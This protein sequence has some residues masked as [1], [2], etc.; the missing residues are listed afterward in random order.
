MKTNL[1]K[2]LLYT[3]LLSHLLHPLMFF[4]DCQLVQS[5]QLF[6][7]W[8][9][10]SIIAFSAFGILVSVPAAFISMF[11]L[12]ILVRSD[13]PVRLSF[14]TWLIVVPLSAAAGGAFVMK[15]VVGFFDPTFLG[16]FVPGMMAGVASVLIRYKQFAKLVRSV[17]DK[18]V[19]SYGQF[20]YGR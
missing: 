14:I 7:S 4:I 13:L 6:F 17:N 2:H 16:I 20:Y 5:N 3:W 10:S 12:R 1:Y 9:P 15:F 11:S 19:P 18:S 8:E